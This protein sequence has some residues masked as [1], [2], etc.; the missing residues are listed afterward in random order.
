MDILMVFLWLFDWD[1]HV[2]LILAKMRKISYVE[3]KETFCKVYKIVW[4]IKV[5]LKLVTLN[6]IFDVSI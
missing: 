3:S 4:A 5:E 2:R 1:K 6:M